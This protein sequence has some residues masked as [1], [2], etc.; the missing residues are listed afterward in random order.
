MTLPGKP[1]VTF[2]WC[3]KLLAT[4]ACSFFW[5]K[6]NL[7]SYMAYGSCGKTVTKEIAY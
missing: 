4:W 5:D 1:D 2:S 3:I 7:N 6:D